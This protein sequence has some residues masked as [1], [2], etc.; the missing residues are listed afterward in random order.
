MATALLNPLNREAE[1]L[2]PQ[3]H[4]PRLDGHSTT[5]VV[6][7]LCPVCLLPLRG[8]SRSFPLPRALEIRRWRK[9]S[10]AAHAAAE[11][12]AEV[13]LVTGKQVGGPGLEG[14]LENRLILRRQLNACR[15]GS[16]LRNHTDP[17]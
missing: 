13:L 15:K 17:F 5:R 4:A 12:G 1:S 10:N 8:C 16:N 3:S 7:T 14:R 2:G 11:I 6:P 9:N